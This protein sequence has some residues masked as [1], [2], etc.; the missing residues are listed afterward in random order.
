MDSPSRDAADTPAEP[1][2]RLAAEERLAAAARRCAGDGPGAFAALC[3]HVV[4]DRSYADST[5]AV[6]AELLEQVRS[7]LGRG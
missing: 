1:A 6:F 3:R 7:T 5:R 2:R 4:G